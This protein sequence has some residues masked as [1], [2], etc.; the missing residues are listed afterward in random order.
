MERLARTRAGF[1]LLEVVIA[2]VLFSVVLL[3]ASHLL[4]SLGNFSSNFVR[5]ESSLTGTALGAFEEITS[6]IEAANEVIIP[7]ASFAAAP[8]IDINVSPTGPAS[9]DHTKDS[10]YIYWQVGTQ[11]MRRSH[12]WDS[13]TAA[14]TTSADSAIA[15]NIQQANPLT[16][17]RGD[18]THQNQITV[19]MNAETHSGPGGNANNV[20]REHLET[21]AIMRSRSAN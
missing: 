1:T 19:I 3:A 8:S 7:S 15:D 18:A 17:T 2:I 9:L 20:T 4:I 21:I 16:F 5:S 13:A 10:T 12:I 14:W 11:L 6:R